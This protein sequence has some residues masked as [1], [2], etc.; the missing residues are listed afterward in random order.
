MYEEAVMAVSTGAASGVL[1]YLLQGQADALRTRISS[2]FRR[3]DSPHEETAALQVLNEQVAAL[4]RHEITGRT[5]TDTWTK[6][7]G[8]FLQAHPDARADVEELKRTAP[9]KTVNVGSQH[10]HGSGAFI[11]SDHYGDININTRDGR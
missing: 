9:T 6:L 11:G 7:L 1:S 8:A 10:N 3:G 2:I 5:I 4:A